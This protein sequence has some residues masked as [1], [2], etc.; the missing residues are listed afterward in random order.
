MK[1][2]IVSTDKGMKAVQAKN[3]KDA[4]KKV[5]EKFTGKIYKTGIL[6]SGCNIDYCECEKTM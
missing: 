6:V 5:S 1:T 4:Y 2:Y 3:K